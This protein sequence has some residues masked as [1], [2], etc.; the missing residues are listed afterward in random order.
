MSVAIAAGELPP[1]DQVAQFGAAVASGRLRRRAQMVYALLVGLGVAPLALHLSAGWQAAGLG[2]ICPGAGFL[3]DGGWAVLLFPFAVALM[4]AAFASWV[5]MAN[6]VAPLVVWFGGAALAGGLAGGHIA[7][8]APWAT[9]LLTAGFFAGCSYLSRRTMAGEAARRD[10]RAIY[11]PAAMAAVDARAVDAPAAGEREMSPADLASLRYAL[12]RG[13]QPVDGFAG[14]DVIEQFQTSSVRYQIDYLLWALQL[15]QCYYTPNFHGYLNQ[16]QRNLI[17]KLTVPMVWKWWR[18]ENLLGN[19]SFNLDPIAKDNIMFGGFSSNHIALYT[20]LTGDERYLEPGS[21]TFRWNESIV[22]KHDLRT[23][24]EAGRKN[25][26]EAVYA[27]LYPCEPRLTYS[28]CNLWGQMAHLTADRIFATNHAPKLLHDLKPLHM[29]EMMGIDGSPHAG[30]MTALGIRIPVYTCNHVAAMW[31]WMAS[32][33]FPDLSRR[34]WAASREECVSFG[35]DGEITLAAEAYDRID[36]GNYKK[37]E[38]GLYAQFLMLAREQGDQEVAEAILRKLDK[39]FG[40]V[41][42]DGVVSYAKAS[43]VNNATIIMGRL[44]RR[45]DMRGLL[46][47]GPPP[48]ALSG[49]VLAEAKYPDVLVAKAY[50]DGEALELVLYAGGAAGPQKLKLG[51]LRPGRSYALAPEGLVFSADAQGGAEIE[52][53]LEGRTQV[54]ITPVRG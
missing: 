53:M 33:F 7:P 54:S 30:R 9:L 23:V 34:T 46:R 20:A 41:E 35:G 26:R 32:P 3:A 44:L 13:L 12:E 40:R 25:Q 48:G 39:D 21:L 1:A 11:L 43:N 47:D 15:S 4:F 45:F 19:F 6:A 29:S 10:A 38:A 28:A 50:S 8:W 22:F 24:L 17:G 27:P 42:R 36:T 37:S 14:F 18:W 52:V 2:V 31:G 49:P 51:R 16:A 5:L